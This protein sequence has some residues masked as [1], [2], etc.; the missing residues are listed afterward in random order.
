MGGLAVGKLLRAADM[1]YTL[2][3]VV[4]TQECT[5]VKA[6]QT[7]HLKIV[8]FLYVNYISHTHT[9]KDRNAQCQLHLRPTKS[10]SA[11]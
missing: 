1:F 4:L 7:P 3:C 2:D 5:F 9:Q 11:F 8:H 10:E 6:H